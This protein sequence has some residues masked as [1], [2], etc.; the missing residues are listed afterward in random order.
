MWL[1]MLLYSL[2]L[3]K[4]QLRLLLSLSTHA[5]QFFNCSG[6]NSSAKD[7]NEV[8]R[9]KINRLRRALILTTD[10]ALCAFIEC[11]GLAQGK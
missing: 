8:R 3:I 5:S 11:A 2:W 4:G 1:F 10:I 7:E 9:K 6:T